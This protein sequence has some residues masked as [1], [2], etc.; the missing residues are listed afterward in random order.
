VDKSTVSLVSL[1]ISDFALLPIPHFVSQ[2]VKQI[3]FVHEIWQQDLR[4]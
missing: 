2:A 1:A 4:F 3:P